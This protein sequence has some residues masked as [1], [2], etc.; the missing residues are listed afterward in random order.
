MTMPYHPVRRAD[1]ADAEA[2]TQILA[3][4]FHDDPPLMWILP[5]PADRAALSGAFFRPFVELVLADGRADISAD[6]C[7]CAL[8]LDVDVTTKIEEDPTSFRQQFIDGIGPQ[9]AA[10]FFILDDLFSAGHPTHES[11]AYLLFVGVIPHRQRQGIGTALLSSRLTE[12]D[13]AGR[14][15]YLEASSPDNAA[16]YRRLGFAPHGDPVNLPGGPSLF[17][18]WRAPHAV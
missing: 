2:L 4:G 9:G 13:Q 8:W 10:R 15:S 5:D 1:L 12:L 14:P 7:G 17:P 3:R 18:M 6:G 11:H 16:L